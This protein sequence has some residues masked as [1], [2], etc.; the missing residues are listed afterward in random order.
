MKNR[1]REIKDKTRKKGGNEAKRGEEENGRAREGEE[2]Q[3][4]I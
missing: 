4:E 2:G 1:K 3:Q